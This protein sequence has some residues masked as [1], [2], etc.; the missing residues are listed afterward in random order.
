[1]DDA[2]IEQAV[3]SSTANRDAAIISSS[4]TIMVVY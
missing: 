1:M 3:N 2:S 4:K